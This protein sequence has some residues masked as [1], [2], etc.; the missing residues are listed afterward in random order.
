M[1]R[2]AC[3][4]FLFGLAVTSQFF[5]CTKPQPSQDETSLEIKNRLLA[6]GSSAGISVAG[7]SIHSHQYIR[8]FYE[9]RAFRP[10]WTGETG[11]VAD[12]DTLLAAIQDAGYDGLEPE[13]YHLSAIESTVSRMKI[14]RQISPSQAA[15]YRA[16]IEFLSTDGYLLY[17]SDLSEGKVDPDSLRPRLA[18]GQREPEYVARLERAVRNHSIRGSLK[19][20][21]PGHAYYIGLRKLLSAFEAVARGGGWKR[22]PPGPPLSAGETGGR[23]DALIA[24]LRISGDL[25]SRGKS[26]LNRFDSTLVEA[27]K[28][29]QIRHGL[30]ATGVVDSSTIVVLNVPVNNRIEQIKAN[31][32]RWRWMPHDLGRRHIL[33]NVPDFRIFVIEDGSEV[34]SMKV[35]LGLPGWQTP[36]FSADLTQ[37]LFN[38]HW[39]A[40]K[41]IVERELINYMKAD[42]N[43][44]R[45]N[46]MT[47]WR[48]LGDTLV[49]VDPR[50]INWSLMNAKN[51]D[52]RLRQEGGAQNIMG[53]VKFLIPNKYNIYLHDTP[54]RE[55]FPKDIRMFSHGCIRLEKPLDLAAYVLR[56][57]PG[58]SRVRIDTVVARRDEQS[59][60]LKNPIPVHVLY[61]TVWR[62]KDGS[63]Q[64][65][66][67]FY[68]LDRALEAQLRRAEAGTP[69]ASRTTLN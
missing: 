3:I 68:G 13:D 22:V 2:A 64:F 66:E 59:I 18:I 36:L 16:D 33:I 24:R 53:Q 63:A 52:F 42:S 25:R 35:V 49:Q 12:L 67:D 20:L 1:R 51:I 17:A 29:F 43:Y 39:M 26:N 41:D 60:F 5:G 28:G 8:L 6:A 15:L 9:G 45:G 34:M 27:V 19:S 38:S 61:F 48:E 4:Q 55:D 50:T 54:Y 40:P 56:D 57:V 31:L 37:V 10:V 7:D 69:R 65:R 44:L 62:G 11:A 32:E 47:L 46:E 30:E 14:D 23:V 21:S 58:W